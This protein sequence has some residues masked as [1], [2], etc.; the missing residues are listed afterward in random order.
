MTLKMTRRSPIFWFLIA[1]GFLILA[2]LLWLPFGLKTTG[3]MEEWM[4]IH[5][6]N[7]GG[8]SPVGQDVGWFITTGTLT[9]RPLTAVSFLLAHELV[10]DSFIAFN[11]MMLVMFALKGLLL[12]AILNQLLPGHTL[13]SLSCAALFVIFPAD[14]ALFT[15]RAFNCH[16]AVNAWLLAVLLFLLNYRHWRWW[17]VPLVWLSLIVCLWTYEAAYPLVLLTPTVLLWW[18]GRF[19]KHIVRAALLWWLA[20]IVAFLYVAIQFATGETYQS[21]V[22]QRSGLTNQ[23]VLPE[24]VEALWMAYRRHFADG[25]VL[26]AT[27]FFPV[28]TLTLIGL[29]FA[30]ITICGAWLGRRSDLLKE[31][32]SNRVSLRRWVWMFVGGMAIIGLG[33]VLYMLTPYR[34][35]TWRVY[36]YSHL[37]G[38]LCV[39]IL[40]WGV[41]HLAKAQRYRLFSVLM[42]AMLSLAA[43]RAL[44]SHRLFVDMSNN[45]Q[46]LLRD[47]VHEAPRLRSADSVLVVVDETR[48]FWSN[49]SLGASYLLENALRVVYDDY[50]IQAVLCSFDPASQQFRTLPE[51]YETCTITQDGLTV[52]T[53]RS[54]ERQSERDILWDNAAIIHFTDEGGALLDVV[55]EQYT[56]LQI[57]GYVPQNV[58]DVAA[59]L[60]PRW[61]TMF[62][63]RPDERPRPARNALDE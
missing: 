4:I 31:I 33:Y 28:D 59:P 34:Q 6:W 17:Y 10:P 15:F 7:L 20:P 47:V 27:H 53:G 22:L 8:I 55:P 30:T 39:T 48:R 26:G 57:S 54:G 16:V 51:L 29:L 62:S 61:Y 42:G 41:A 60:P 14:A 13:F 38:A 5:D 40:I 25:F 9:M 21:W 45:E 63:L 1:I 56:S 58:V 35:L 2:G 49:W 50:T 44:E 52:M 46:E 23:S 3:L 24:I 32:V 43:V 18:R 12:F 37:G 11:L 36:Y 19:E